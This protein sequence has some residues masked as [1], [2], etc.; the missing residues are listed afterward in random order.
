MYRN[1]IGNYEDRQKVKDQ[2]STLKCM[3]L[4]VGNGVGTDPREQQ[5]EG[6]F[7]RNGETIS[8]FTE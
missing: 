4:P 5:F 3:I 1:I 7:G 8:G 6:V 2:H